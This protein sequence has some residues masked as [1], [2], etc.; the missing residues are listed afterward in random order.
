MTVVCDVTYQK[1]SLRK[2]AD[3]HWWLILVPGLGVTLMALAFAIRA[4]RS[5]SFYFVY[6]TDAPPWVRNRVFSLL[7]GGVALIVGTAT[8]ASADADLAAPAVA[9]MLVTWAAVIVL[10]VWLFRPPEMM[11]PRWLRDVERGTAAEPPW[12]AAAFGVPGAGAVR[13]IYCLR[14]ST[15]AHGRRTACSSSSGSR[16]TGRGP[17]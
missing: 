17:G 12:L 7:P 9:F 16:S 4:G 11:K 3:M 15:G 8:V 6:R 13:R 2:L 10:V 1:A 5:R 14:P